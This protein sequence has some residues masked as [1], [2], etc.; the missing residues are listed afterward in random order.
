[1][2]LGSVGLTD[3]RR[4]GTVEYFELLQSIA[5]FQSQLQHLLNSITKYGTK[6]VSVA[7]EEGKGVG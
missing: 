5:T 6:H 2:R 4:K 7:M 3:C 1:M